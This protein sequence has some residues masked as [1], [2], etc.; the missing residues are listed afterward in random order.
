MR[1]IVDEADVEPDVPTVPSF[2]VNE[3]VKAFEKA[4]FEMAAAPSAKTQ[5]I[6]PASVEIS[7]G[8]K[9]LSIP[10]DIEFVVTE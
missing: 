4:K 7:F 8:M 5:Y 1:T 6:V 9:M 2:V 10:L 3:S